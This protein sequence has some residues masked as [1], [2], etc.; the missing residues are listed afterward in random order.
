M[1]SNREDLGEKLLKLKKDAEREK[2][3]RSELEGELK[4]L[5]ARMKSEFG[6]DSITKAEKSVEGSNKELSD[7][8]DQLTKKIKDIEALLHGE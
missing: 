3:N 2:T 6:E 5:K 7:L 1:A 4:S 8:N